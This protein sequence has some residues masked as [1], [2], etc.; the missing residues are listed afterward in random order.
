MWPI[1]GDPV[2]SFPHCWRCKNRLKPLLQCSRCRKATYC[3]RE[4]QKR[5]WARHKGQCENLAEKEVN[6]PVQPV[7]QGGGLKLKPRRVTRK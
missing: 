5:D 6:V 1:Q 7:Q 2:L 3:G 4:C